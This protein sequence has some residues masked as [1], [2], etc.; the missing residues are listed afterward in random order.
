[1][2]KPRNKGFILTLVIITIILIG[3][4][5][6]I[7][8]E[9]AKTIVFQSN[10][11]YLEALEQNLTA[12]G[13]AWAKHNIKDKNIE[14]FSKDITLDV[15]NMNVQN[16]TLSVVIVT[17]KDDKAEV[18]L[19]TSCSRGRRILKHHDKYIIKIS[20]KSQSSE[21]RI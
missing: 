12:S 5:M 15:T 4:M 20:N 13:L 1:M 14:T 3:I 11:A 7:L 21:T 8:T 6:T 9:G 19:S 2:T 10:N 17:I 16:A 18:E